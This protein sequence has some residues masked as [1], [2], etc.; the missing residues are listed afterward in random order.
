MNRN[1]WHVFNETPEAIVQKNAVI[2]VYPEA[3]ASLQRQ[4][5]KEAERVK[6]EYGVKFSVYY[7]WDEM[8]LNCP[9]L[10]F[11]VR[12]DGKVDFCG[13]W[14]RDEADQNIDLKNYVLV[15]KTDQYAGFDTKMPAEDATALKRAVLAFYKKQGIEADVFPLENFLEFIAENKG[16]FYKA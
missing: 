4:L 14:V 3:S 9:I 12:K 7:Q 15:K 13:A 10:D 2:A 8:P 6:S 5:A 16:A 11:M 1:L